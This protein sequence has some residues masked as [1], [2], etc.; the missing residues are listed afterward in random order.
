MWR[1]DRQW[2]DL[3]KTLFGAYREH[4]RSVDTTIIVFKRYVENNPEAEI[5]SQTFSKKSPSRR[6][7]WR[8]LGLCLEKKA[9]HLC[10]KK[11]GA[12]KENLHLAYA[13]A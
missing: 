1:P 2:T 3:N 13:A 8:F 10:W 12:V 4:V 6:F 9:R 5:E 11:R 7:I